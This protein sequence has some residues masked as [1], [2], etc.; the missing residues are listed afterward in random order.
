[1]VKEKL[2]VVVHNYVDIDAIV[3]AYLISKIY[4]VA[5]IY[6]LKEL[7]RIPENA[8]LIVLDTK[9]ARKLMKFKE[10]NR[11]LKHI[12]HHDGSAPSTAELIWREYKDKLPEHARYFV[13]LANACDTGEVIRQKASIAFFHI[14]GYVRAL[15]EI[16]QSDR[17]IINTVM[18]MLSV[19]E[20]F[21]EKYVKA[22]KDAEKA[23][24][25][26]IGDLEV[27]VAEKYSSAVGTFLFKEK[28]VDLVIYKDGYSMGVLRNSD[29]EDLNLAELKPYVEKL[30]K[31][32]GAEKE[33]EE[34]HF[35]TRGF[36]ACRGTR[37]H[38]ARSES[39]LK[40]KDLVKAIALWRKT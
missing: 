6:T 29:R 27:A 13:D 33:L 19:W 37:K 4:P 15:H 28:G 36:I 24:I 12:D 31:E 8:K 25:L 32:K 10:Y 35:D 38:P 17:N 20:K 34:W 21:L 5:N 26:T 30:L 18:A 1:M 11:I 7:E 22:K 14:S 39:A 40:P 9:I 16:K 3:S 23:E 2:V